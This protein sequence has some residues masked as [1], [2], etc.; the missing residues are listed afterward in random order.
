M[1]AVRELTT[2]LVLE[3]LGVIA[4]IKDAKK[5]V[6]EISGSKAVI[7]VKA[8]VAAAKKQLEETKNT[9]KSVTQ[10]A[11]Q[12]R[13]GVL[14]FSKSLSD[15]SKEGSGL[16][17]VMNRVRSTA[18]GV[19]GALVSAGDAGKSAAAHLKAN[20]SD[21]EGTISKVAAVASAAAA[22]SVYVAAGVQS[23]LGTIEAMRGKEY[24]QQFE[25]WINEA[26]SSQNVSIS[27]RASEV[28]MLGKHFQGLEGD[29]GKEFLA[30]MEKEMARETG[31]TVGT[32]KMLE[33]I[34]SGNISEEFLKK[35]PGIDIDTEKLK[36]Q[37]EAYYQNPAYMRS[38]AGYSQ[39]D[40]QAELFAEEF[41]KWGNTQ[42]LANGKT[43]AASE[44]GTDIDTEPLYKMQDALTNIGNV[45]GQEL[46]PYLS[47][48]V[49]A[50]VTVN[51]LLQSTPGAAKFVALAVGIG[52][53]ASSAILAAAGVT[54]AANA[55]G[56][57]AVASKVFAGGIGVA[58]AAMT[59]MAAHPIIAVLMIL[60][61]LLILVEAKTGIFS[62]GLAALCQAAGPA[63]EALVKLWDIFTGSGGEIAG[64]VISGVSGALGKLSG[65]ASGGLK[66][67][68]GGIS[69]KL[70]IDQSDL[71]SGLKVGLM[72]AFP[73][74]GLAA[75][76]THIPSMGKSL[77]ESLSKSDV[78]SS[79]TS[80]IVMWIGMIYDLLK[81]WINIFTGLY[82]TL[83]SFWEWVVT[84]PAEI[85]KILPEYLGGGEKLEGQ[86]LY[87]RLVK[88]LPEYLQGQGYAGAN[89]EQAEWLSKALTG[90]DVNPDDKSRLN[91]ND[92]MYR[93]AKEYSD[94]LSGG[95]DESFLE[96]SKREGTTIVDTVKNSG[97]LFDNSAATKD[98]S[99]WEASKREGLTLLGKLGITKNDAGGRVTKSGL[100]IIDAGERIET[101]DVVREEST[102][103]KLINVAKSGSVFSGTGV[104]QANNAHNG[105]IVQL[106]VQGSLIGEAKIASDLDIEDLAEKLMWTMR[107]KLED[108][109]QRTSGLYEG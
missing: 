40:I 93:E 17:S 53:V 22:G 107:G 66:G 81:P 76:A 23:S 83:A 11:T 94:K 14:L 98:E 34:G 45:L 79:L 15:S 91:I 18:A 25:P 48:F 95:T 26:S 58:R 28:E 51:A 89:A 1:V 43:L 96:A 80:R 3:N 78:M 73:V 42:K 61:G 84:L 67:L 106:I 41:T 57:G 69:A 20:W 63:Y 72:A 100:G 109:M 62:K 30:L 47:M 97:G 16:D 33:M 5:T 35:L 31:S 65:L 19:K 46:K 104:S 64:K 88:D 32:D 105:R 68:A 49:G 85:K 13:A 75:M 37:A 103:E 77:L 39:K 36:A 55:L 86:N 82:N 27:T 29:K 44:W 8:D 60:I 71:K 74:F 21:V 54:T 70:G 101:A 10:E 87:D 52:A 108:L 12:T 56:V 102:L 90:Q 99:F 38:H 9:L 6:D 50:L 59:L 7:G 2:R 92:A 4:Q 24:R